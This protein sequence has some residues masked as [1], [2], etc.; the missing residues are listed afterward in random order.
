MTA[1]ELLKKLF[2]LPETMNDFDAVIYAYDEY[3]NLQKPM[4]T[5]W[6]TYYLPSEEES[7]EK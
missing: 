7:D 2:K 1:M 6:T 3:K 4:N 5:V